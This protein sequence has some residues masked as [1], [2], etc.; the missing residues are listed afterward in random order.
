MLKKLLV[1]ASI[2]L[3]VPAFAQN[4]QQSG[5]VTRNHIPVW[6]TSGAIGDGGSSAD[7]PIS[8]IGVT[9]NGGS[10][11]CVNSARITSGAYNALCLGA[12]TT[13]P[14]TIS[15]QNFGSAGAQSLQFIIN[16][17][18]FSFP[19]SL[20]Q[21]TI[22]V[23]PVVGGTNSNCLFVSGGVV[24]QQACTLSAITAL[25]G[26]GT[27]TGPGVSTLTL[28]T[29]NSNVGTFGS[30]AVVP[31]IT[32]N[33]K[34]LITA[35]STSPVSITVGSSAIVSGSNQGI[36]YN[37][38]GVF[39]NLGTLAS[40]VLI[41]SAGGVPIMATT[42]PSGL[43]VPGPTFTGTLTFPDAAT[44]TAAG[45]SKMA[46]LSTGSATIPS[47]GNINVSGQYQVSGS[48]IAASNLSN[49]TT[50]SGLVVLQTSPTL[51]GTVAG[52]ITLSGANTYSGNS[53]FTAQGIF[54][55]TSAPASAAGNTIVMG[56]IASPTLTN[57]G[58]AFIYNTTVNGAILEGDGS[59]NDVSL[60]N[61]SGALVF[62]IPTGTTKLNL[63]SLSSGTCSSGLGLDSSNNTILIS[64]PGAASSIQVGTTTITSG[65]SGSIEFNNAGTLGELVPNGGVT[66]SGAN[67]QQDGNYGGWALQNCT[68]AASVATNILTVALKDNS[69]ADPSATS[70]CNINYRNV[71]ATTGSTTLVQQTAAL[72]ITTNATGA[73]LGS[74]NSTAFRFWVVAFNN[75]GTNVLALIN[76]TSQITAGVLT[77]SSLNEGIVASTT[78]ISGSATS[79]GVFYTPNGTT[80]TSKAFRIL[81]YVEYN[82]TGLATAGTYASGPNFI[83]SFGPGIRKPGEVVQASVFTPTGTVTVVTTAGASFA[84]GANS[85]ITAS[86]AP[87]SAANPIRFFATSDA[88][89]NTSTDG[90]LLQM[91]RGGTPTAVGPTNIRIMTA[92]GTAPGMSFSLA[93]YD[94]PNTTSSTAYA[95]RIWTNGAGTASVPGTTGDGAFEE[96]QE[97]MG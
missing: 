42:L 40:S 20:T 53:T 22:G 19:G 4:V 63:P 8:S 79:A 6:V 85:N 37:N 32:V 76:C 25:T 35:V 90:V 91:G 67:L 57:T 61:K 51:S 23:T 24:G 84:A 86:I 33:G 30:G 3:A 81:G 52:S 26:D 70:P 12:S 94:L 11:I 48:Q 88:G 87:T 38:G 72:S 34:G 43:T 71:T 68:L 36:I 93:G 82:S 9:N 16:G 56:T 1:A 92:V 29:V 80:V 2:L 55:G 77:I 39:G 47:A 27:A 13:G 97:I 66:K 21:I 49:G 7:S 31:I 15:L 41:T 96:L 64:C 5:S 45:V 74:A 54:Q 69:G 73:T 83:Q 95:V 60:F 78:P 18:T 10:G 75:A 65:S 17:T 89:N 58:Q 50:G 46:A 59:T 14:A 28:A 62:G 44:W